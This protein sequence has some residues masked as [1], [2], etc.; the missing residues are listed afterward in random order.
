MCS[1]ASRPLSRLAATDLCGFYAVAKRDKQGGGLPNSIVE[2]LKN[3]RIKTIYKQCCGSMAFWGGSWSADPCLW[4]IEPDPD[5]AIFI[6]DLQD[7]SKKLI[8]EHNFSAYYFLKLHLH[9]FSK[10]KV[11]KSHK[12]VGIKVF[13]TIFAWW[14][15]DPDSILWLVDPDPGGQ[16]K[17]DPVDPDS[18]PDP[19]H[20]L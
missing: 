15:K 12:I 10:I 5:P 16:K 8:F 11:K 18:N 14:M 19:Q 7:A 1:C 17:V 2:F 20:C 3:V 9:H 6:T 13:L 4:L